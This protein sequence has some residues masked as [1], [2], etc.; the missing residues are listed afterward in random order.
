MR[1]AVARYLSTSRFDPALAEDA[2]SAVVKRLLERGVST[3][4]GDNWEPYLI[5]AAVNAA[6]DIIK[7]TARRP[8]QVQAAGDVSDCFADTADD[9]S[10]EEDVMVAIDNERKVK[11][12]LAAIDKLPHQQRRAVRGRLLEDKKNVDLAGELGVSAPYV[13]Q[14]YSAGIRTVAA[15]VAEGTP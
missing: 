15:T 7:T 10:M 14:L 8:D 9:T 13:S 3:S 12:V 5:K 2:V 4:V 1:R 11:P 6:K